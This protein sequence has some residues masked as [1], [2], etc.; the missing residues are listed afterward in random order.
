MTQTKAH[1]FSEP[2]PKQ[3]ADESFHEYMHRLYKSQPQLGM[4][5]NHVQA[6]LPRDLYVPFYQFLK[7]KGW[8][9]SKGVQYAIYRL[10]QKDNV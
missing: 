6:K 7:E 8:S 9:K 2:T 3:N 1:G 10:L 4:I 5:N